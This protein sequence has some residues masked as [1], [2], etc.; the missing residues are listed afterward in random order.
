MSKANKFTIRFGRY[1]TRRLETR[2]GGYHQ[3][4]YN[5]LENL[6]KYIRKG[7]VVLV[8]GRSR[9][10]QIIKLFSQSHWSHISMYVGD[11]LI[12]KDSPLREKY[13]AVYGDA[14][15][16]LVIEAFTGLGVVASP[17]IKYKDYNLRVCRAFGIKSSDLRTVINEVISNLGKSYDQQNI[18]DIALMLLPRWLNPFQR[19]S[20]VACLGHCST[21]KVICS[22]MI[23]NAFQK[24]GYPVNPA[25]KQ[26][27]DDENN[28][29]QNPYG[30]KLVM[31]HHSQI[32][33]RDFDL[34]P[35]F[36][37][38]KFNIVKGRKFKYKNLPWD[39]GVTASD[40]IQDSDVHNTASEQ[41]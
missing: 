22:G 40:I 19:Q 27:S 11:E 31:R 17:L 20:I 3:R 29:S 1:L 2:S 30:S 35:T 24:V 28:L 12:K 14:A 34:S 37:I 8:E 21:Y 15:E 13:L 33:P 5:N 16:H 39:E 10:S 18:I 41:H 25:L 4:I 26:F 32:L 7:D 36:K 9:L 23:A 6:K 38:V